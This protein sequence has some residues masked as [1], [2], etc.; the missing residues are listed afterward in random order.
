MLRLTR[1]S[2]DEQKK[3]LWAASD[4]PV[5]S[6]NLLAL[7]GG[8][9]STL[10]FGFAHDLCRREIG[11]GHRDFEVARAAMQQWIEFD[12]EWVKV[13]NPNSRVLSGELVAVEAHTA[14]LWSI[15]FSRVVEVVNTPTKFGF[16][17][18]T[19]ALHI[20][21]GQE[22]FLIEFDPG[23]EAVFYVIEAVSRP[24]HVLARIGYPISRTMQHRFQ[25]DSIV[26]MKHAV[27]ES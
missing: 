26:R 2:E 5:S 21:E 10:P 7:E 22:R 17:Y 18:T 11:R 24:R 1:A 20:E 3:L 27:L 6:P 12:L 23:N 4:A 13:I 9:R 15:N 19:T 8:L 25:R 14:Y 16:M